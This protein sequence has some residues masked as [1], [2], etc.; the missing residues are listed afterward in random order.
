MGWTAAGGEIT[1]PVALFL[2]FFIFMWQM[3]HFWLL[4]LKYGN[5][6]RKAGFPVLNDLFSPRQMKSIVMVWLLVLVIALSDSLL[7][8]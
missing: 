6:Y 8:K 2:A 1:D 3:P 4:M 5:D 7:H